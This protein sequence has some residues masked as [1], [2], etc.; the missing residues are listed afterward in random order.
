ME[1]KDEDKY[2]IVAEVGD[3][4]APLC[5]LNLPMSRLLE[6][7]VSPYEDGEPFRI[8]GVTVDKNTLRRFKIVK[9]NENFETQLED[10]GYTMRRWPKDGG[11]ELAQH[12]NTIFD[13]LLRNNTVDITNQLINAYKDKKP[14][15]KPSLIDRAKAFA[16]LAKTM[17]PI[18]KTLTGSDG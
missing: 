8:D 15:E 9:Q 3:R 13:D 14:Q 18:I 2:A 5:E 1:V 10:M 4:E 11:K 17:E 6:A 12:Y 7:Y 16:E